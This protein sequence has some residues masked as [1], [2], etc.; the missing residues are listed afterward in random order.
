MYRGVPSI[1]LEGDERRAAALIPLGKQLLYKLQSLCDR[2]EVSTHS[3]SQ[4][5]GDDGL[6]Y[7]L[8]AKEQ[9]IISISVD[10]VIPDEI[11]PKKPAPE[12]YLDPDI[13]SGLIYTGYLENRTR[14][15]AD[16]NEVIY[17]VCADFAPTARCVSYFDELETQGSQAV[18]RL[19][20]DPWVANSELA[21]PP[22]FFAEFSQYTKLRP[23]MYSGTMAKVVQLVMGLGRTGGIGFKLQG[24]SDETGYIAEVD[25][26]GVQIRYDYKFFR[27]HGITYGADGTL[28]LVE[29]GVNR[30]VIVRPLPIFE[31]SDTENYR[32]AAKDSGHEDLYDALIEVGVLPTGEAFPSGDQINDFYEEGTI[33]QLL[34]PGELTEFY[35]NQP[36]STAMGWAFNLEGSEA[37]NTGYRFEDDGYQ[38]GVWYQ[39]S[40][41][42]GPLI[43]EREP[44]DPIAQASA[45]LKL[46]E[47]RPLYATPT[48]LGRYLPVKFYEPLLPGLKSHDAAPT[49]E[50]AG[51]PI[52]K[53]DTTMYVAFVNG[54][55]KSMKYYF[56]ASEQAYDDI[57][58]PRYPGECLV[59]SDWTIVEQSGTR[60]FP[61]MPYTND[62]DPR[63]VLQG[64]VKTT[65]IKSRDKG[66]LPPQ[67]SDFIQFPEIAF[68]FRRR[69]FETTT[70]IDIKDG[71]RIE[72]VFIAPEYC[73]EAYYYA[74]GHKYDGSHSGST[75]VGYDTIVDPNWGYSFRNFPSTPGSPWPD[76][77][78]CDIANC[79]GTRNAGGPHSERR[80]ICIGYGAI[81]S[82]PV[83]GG[84]EGASCHEFADAGQWLQLCQIVD[85]FNAG[86]VEP[87]PAGSSFNDGEEKTADLWLTAT[88]FNG[89]LKIPGF[90]YDRFENQWQAPSPDPITLITQFIQATASVL[91]AEAIV[92]HTDL[93]GLGETALYGV[94]S[95]S[96]TTTSVIPCFIG[97]NGP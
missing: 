54:S 15:D 24:E 11:T 2:A 32:L 44:G 58:D 5:V 93:L 8:V 64:Y 21:T 9:N 70:E 49:A 89:S 18:E 73:R 74:V 14:F 55:F 82:G 66:F 79:G 7:V 84:G 35:L 62:N 81:D 60:S 80:I 50:S 85:G 4:K 43:L 59:A 27:T 31:L 3:R 86:G 37:H 65:T 48:P 17:K 63:I 67:F 61:A 75:S 53:C 12:G 36:Y 57:Q 72:A 56:N 69:Q 30:G 25:R 28:W 76:D 92:Y 91:G 51:N 83:H 42:I 46:L 95:D 26:L 68:V 16:G 45:T 52:P 10:P 22:G 41:D 97:V 20:I 13:Y 88:G 77:I 87:E 19:A 78:G 94:A 38:R 6:I 33:L 96:I 23:S 90:D 47:Q 71:E 29:I 1:R 39:I 34:A 40:I